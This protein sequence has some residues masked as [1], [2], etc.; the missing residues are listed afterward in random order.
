MFVFTGLLKAADNEAQ[1]AGVMAHEMAH[2]ILRHG[3]N[4]ASKANLLQMPA[5]LAGAVVGSGS[6]ARATRASGG[7][8]W[9][10][11]RCC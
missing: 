11:T 5:L 3:T 8:D 6:H 7:R 1:L 2:V 10:R 9:G 4:Q